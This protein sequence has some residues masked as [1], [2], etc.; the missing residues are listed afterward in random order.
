[1]HGYAGAA[2]RGLAGVAQAR[3]GGMGNTHMSHAALSEEGLRAPDRAV[4][5]LI[6]DH[7]VPGCQLVTK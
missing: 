1:M 4:D 7:K 2:G 6:D 5:E 3:A